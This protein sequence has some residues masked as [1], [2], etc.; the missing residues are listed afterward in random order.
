MSWP[1]TFC[2]P[3]TLKTWD[4]S[5]GNQQDAQVEAGGFQILKMFFKKNKQRIN[6][7]NMNM[8][9]DNSIQNYVICLTYG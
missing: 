6:G 1:C 9:N 3:T 5:R 7:E 8:G 2:Q 4:L